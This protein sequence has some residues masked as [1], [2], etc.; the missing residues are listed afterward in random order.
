MA[1]TGGIPANSTN[2]SPWSSGLCDCFSDMESCCCTTWCPCVP[3]GQ[4]S[5]IIDEGSTSCF[6]NALIFCLIASFTPCICLYT[7]SYR[8][9]LRRK[10]NLQETPCNDCCVHYWCWSCAICQEYRELKHRGFDM[11]IG[12]QEN[13]QRRNKG[14]EI[15]PVV[16]GEMKR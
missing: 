5:E 2:G 11:H 9:R 15:P 13:V 1:S 8:S 7:C 14:I 10:Y 4:T 16:E 6:G 12:W 3:F